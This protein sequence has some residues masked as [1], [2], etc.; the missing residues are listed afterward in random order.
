MLFCSSQGIA[1]A[2]IFQ[3]EANDQLRGL[4]DIMVQIFPTDLH[5]DPKLGEQSYLAANGT[6]K[7]L[8]RGMCN[9]C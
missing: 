8:G 7:K 5:T 3:F 4:R 1:G 9:C 6:A 2:T